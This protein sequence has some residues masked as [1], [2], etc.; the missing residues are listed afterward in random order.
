MKKMSLLLAVIALFSGKAM[1]DEPSRK[2]AVAATLP[3]AAPV[4]R[5]EA[6]PIVI[7]MGVGFTGSKFGVINL[8][9]RDLINVDIALNPGFMSLGYGIRVRKLKNRGHVELRP[10]EFQ[11]DNG[12][13]FDPRREEPSYVRIEATD[14]EGVKYFAMETVKSL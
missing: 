13:R 14:A 7:K 5:R 4:V 1:Y 12:M 9:G 6:D 3:P 10:S 8:S 2:E 11:K